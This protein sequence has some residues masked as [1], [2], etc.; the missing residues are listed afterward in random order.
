MEACVGLKRI[1]GGPGPKL[2]AQDDQMFLFGA[3]CINNRFIHCI[4]QT[5]CL[6]LRF[7]EAKFL[8]R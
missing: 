2:A 5:F 8:H 1:F 3:I 7:R 6:V 4:D